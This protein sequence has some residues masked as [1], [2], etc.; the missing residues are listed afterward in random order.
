MSIVRVQG[1]RQ[2]GADAYP[3]GPV[4]SATIMLEIWELGDTAGSPTGCRSVDRWI[5][6]LG[7]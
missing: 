3:T 7:R 2:Q 4:G 5:A 1:V 6:T